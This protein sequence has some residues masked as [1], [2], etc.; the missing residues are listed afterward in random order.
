MNWIE[1]GSCDY[2]TIL[3]SP[4]YSENGWGIIVEPVTDY[5]KKLRVMHNVSYINA[6]VTSELRGKHDFYHISQP[7]KHNIPPWTR[8]C[9]SLKS[10]HATLK[11]F[12]Y[13]AF[14][15]VTSVNC[16]DLAQLYTYFPSKQIHLL[17]VDTEGCDYE[18]L[19]NWDYNTYK[20]MQI[21]YESKLMTVEQDV[22]LR[23]KLHDHGYNVTYGNKVDYAGVPYNSY[24]VQ[25]L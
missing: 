13:D 23:K 1:I 15:E 24:A 6:A 17:K 7:H 4:Y 20:P 11:Y 10:N 12:G 14:A 3:D 22:E 16:I 8:T 2:D 21:Q 25:D 19:Y 18:I 9:G 5:I